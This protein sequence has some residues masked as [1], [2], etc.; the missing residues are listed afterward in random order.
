MKLEAV[1]RMNPDLICVAT[2]TNVIGDHFL[3]HFDEWDDSYDYWCGDDCPYIRPVGWCKENN[4]NLNPPNGKY[5]RSSNNMPCD[6]LSVRHLYIL[7]V[8]ELSFGH[9][10]KK[11][12]RCNE[13]FLQNTGYV[14]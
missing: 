8:K 10:G 4:R 2:V 1:D 11:R 5:W 3:V 9:K 12:T 14:P 13:S 6:Y 7:V